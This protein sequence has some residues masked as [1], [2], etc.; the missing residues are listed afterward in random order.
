M[1]LLSRSLSR[2]LALALLT[3]PVAAR[4]DVESKL[5]LYETE[6]RQ[7]A[8]TLP[9]PGDLS[10]TQQQ[11]RLTDAEVAFSLGDYDQA[12]LML[13]DIA[14]RQGPEHEPALYYLAESLYQKG[15]KGAARTYFQQVV[16]INNYAGKLYQPS[17]IRL[18]EIGIDANDFQ[19]S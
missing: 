12:A 6:A 11:R 13:F 1:R 7:I 19:D 16:D 10:S 3:L 4:A 8:Q 17:L 9:R 14:S 2:I 5:G 15:D 18:V